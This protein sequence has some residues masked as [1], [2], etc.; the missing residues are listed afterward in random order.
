MLARPPRAGGPC[1]QGVPLVPVPALGPA[2]VAGLGQSSVPKSKAVTSRGGLDMSGPCS[3]ATKGC[4]V[5]PAQAMEMLFSFTMPQRL[6]FLFFLC[7][8][9]CGP[10]KHF[11]NPEERYKDQQDVF[12]RIS[13]QFL[14]GFTLALTL[15]TV[16]IRPSAGISRLKLVSPGQ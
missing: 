15:C 16:L 9:D 11:L 12:F 8:S 1:A 14:C 7:R 3:D 10:D 13:V 4:S 5:S 6:H 2:R